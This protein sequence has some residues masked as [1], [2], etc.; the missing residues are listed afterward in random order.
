MKYDKSIWTPIAVMVAAIAI[1]TATLCLTDMSF[2]NSYDISIGQKWNYGQLVATRQF[3]ATYTGEAADSIRRQVTSAFVPKAKV[4]AEALDE[5]LK[6]HPDVSKPVGEALRKL[7][8]AGIADDNLAAA[9]AADFV[10]RVSIMGKDGIYQPVN[11]ATLVSRHTAVQHLASTFDLQPEQAAALVKPNVAIDTVNNRQLLETEIDNAL[12]I[13]QVAENDVI[14]EDDDV[15]TPVT[16]HVLVSYYHKKRSDFEQLASKRWQVMIG[17]VL[18]VVLLMLMFNIYLFAMRPNFLRDT[19]RHIFLQM[20]LALAIVLAIYAITHAHNYR[21]VIPLAL[22]PILV[23]VFFDSRTAFAS[24]L[25][26]VLTTSL[27]VGDRSQYVITQ[28]IGGWMAIVSMQELTRRSQLVRCAG[29]AFIGYTLAYIALTMMR[30]FDM[31][32]LFS[33]GF[34]T[35][36]ENHIFEL[37]VIK[38]F[39]VNC[40]T[41]SFSYVAIYVIERMFGFTSMATLVELTD[42]NTPLMRELSEKCQGTFQHSLQV[43]TLASEAALAVGANVQLVRAGALYHDIGKINNP[44]FFTENQRGVNPHDALVPEQ[45]ASIVISHVSEGVKLARGAN[46]PKIIIDM[47]LQH[48]GHGRAKF[49]YNKAINDAKPG[50]VIDPTPYTYPG[51]NPETREAAILMMADACEAAFKS[52]PDSSDKAIRDMVERIIDGQKADGMFDDAPVTLRDIKTIKNVI[53]ER[54]RSFAIPRVQY[55]EAKTEPKADTQTVDSPTATPS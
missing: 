27:V 42:I 30:G 48:H 8:T 20:L 55:I 7:Y 36:N 33:R 39:A 46:L 34:F 31:T 17:K 35:G 4:D 50:T 38:Y 23:T 21:Y 32:L 24:L 43:A 44:A 13:K 49:F 1:V 22:V 14:I 25:T 45:S 51:P 54:L 9:I 2:S 5:T 53:V 19:K 28:L 29:I 52:L 10:T 41:L 26:L 6:A 40:V 12:F 47:I 37:T 16:Y 3:D 18:M 11:V 15:I